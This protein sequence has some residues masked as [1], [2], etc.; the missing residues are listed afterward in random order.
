MS[1][2][3]RARQAEVIGSLL[4][5][6]VPLSS[7]VH[8]DDMLSWK[9]LLYDEVGRNV[10]APLFKVR[11]L[12]EMGVTLHMKLDAPR[13]PVPGAP[14]V[15]LCEPTEKNISR[16]VDDCNQELFQ[17]FYINFTSSIPRKMLESLA[18]QL[19]AGGKLAAVRHIKVIDRSLEY[20]A[21]ANDLFS[22][23]LPRT[24][25]K[26]NSRKSTDNEIE[27]LMHQ[28]VTRL[29]HVCST[30]QVV[31][32]V[33]FSRTA[34]V[35]QEVGKQ[36][37][38]ALHDQIQER[39]LTQTSGTRPLLL[40]VDRASDFTAAL[41]H[42]FSYQGLLVDAMGMSLNKVTVQSEGKEKVIEV[43]AELDNFFRANCHRDF[44]EI[45][46]NVELAVAKYRQ[47]AAALSA[48]GVEE[49]S[50]VSQA[51]ANAPKLA[52]QKRSLDAHT[53][54]AYSILQKIRENQLDG[55]H[56]VELGLIHQEGLDREHF[57]KL[58]SSDSSSILDKQRLC[59]VAI[60]M[61]SDDDLAYVESKI[62][63][64]GAPFAAL[65]YVRHL[66]ALFGKG[67]GNVNSSSTNVSGFTGFAQ[68]LAKNF[69][70]SL[71]STTETEFPLTRLVDALTQDGLLAQRGNASAKAKLIEKVLEVV[72]AIV[73]K[74][75]LCSVC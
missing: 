53:I 4:V 50:A 70:N 8:D 7:A 66:N 51:L 59:L 72:A 22:A 67:H 62:S 15:Y 19:A 5:E 30:L 74:N 40:I 20:V 57:D 52:E 12:R 13:E 25:Y 3:L 41:H 18:E 48:D 38:A 47:E 28:M 9:V 63:L 61:A 23:M 33:S 10:I 24:F 54:L 60:F 6:A 64:L 32:I 35:A 16:I 29:S 58:L 45:G 14:A 43:D 42:P 36:V 68:S 55:F 44:S 49:A 26:L 34:G 75:I 31:P 2:G 27:Q 11:D 65:K 56:G 39:L 71:K 1:S 69:T 37:V 46:S 17:W 21:M 73:M